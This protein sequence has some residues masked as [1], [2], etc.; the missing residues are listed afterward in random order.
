VTFLVQ[1]PVIVGAVVVVDAAAAAAAAIAVD[2]ESTSSTRNFRKAALHFGDYR[3]TKRAAYGVRCAYV[4]L[5]AA[6]V[7]VHRSHVF[8]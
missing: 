3:K 7:T 4:P 6:A 5:G 2:V 1:P 8:L